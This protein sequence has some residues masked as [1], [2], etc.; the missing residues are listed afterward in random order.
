M[1]Y[2]SITPKITTYPITEYSATFSHLGRLL[3]LTIHLRDI[4]SS[5]LL[6]NEYGMGARDAIPPNL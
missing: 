2:K 3:F 1:P 5:I 4:C 6:V